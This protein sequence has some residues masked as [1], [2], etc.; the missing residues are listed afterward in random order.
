MNSKHKRHEA[1]ESQD[2][3]S[4]YQAAHSL[5]SSSAN[6]ATHL[7]AMCIKIEALAVFRNPRSGIST[8]EKQ[9]YWKGIKTGVH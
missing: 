3:E 8:G 9:P 4:A 6:L 7:A 2:H 5:K 1:A